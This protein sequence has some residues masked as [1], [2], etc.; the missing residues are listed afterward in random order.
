MTRESWQRKCLELGLDAGSDGMFVSLLHVSENT[1]VEST[2]S[3]GVTQMAATSDVLVAVPVFSW[4]PASDGI[5]H[6]YYA[7]NIASMIGAKST[8]GASFPLSIEPAPGGTF[9]LVGDAIKFSGGVLD[10]TFFSWRAFPIN[11]RL[12]YFIEGSG[13]IGIIIDTKD[14]SAVVTVTR[15]G[16]PVQMASIRGTLDHPSFTSL[17]NKSNAW[18][19]GVPGNPSTLAGGGGVRDDHYRFYVST[20]NG[21]YL[22]EGIRQEVRCVAC[23]D[24]RVTREHC[25][26]RWLADANG[27]QPVV[28]NILCKECNLYFGNTLEEPVSRA[29]LSDG[30]LASLRQ[31]VF[32]RWAVKT[33]LMTS[34]ASGVRVNE[35]WFGELRRGRVPENFQVFARTNIKGNAGYGYGV[36]FF[37]PAARAAGE[38]FFMLASP[39]VWILVVGGFPRSG[40]MPALPRV[41]P[42][43]AAPSGQGAPEDTQQYFE[44][45]LTT[46]TGRKFQFEGAG[47]RPQPPHLRG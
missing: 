11:K 13:T 42:G 18:S 9:K 30:N 1:S 45:A 27:V 8:T 43:L 38:F 12:K 6:A 34:A 46:V 16:G 40:P 41:Y 4:T 10:N 32:A 22:P 19:F 35:A 15:D 7:R 23:G 3:L 5:L 14:F 39:T 25:V 37:P 28:A 26:P 21:K 33:A 31:D 36:T 2:N 47:L 24:S 17:I 29:I 20:R 44:Q